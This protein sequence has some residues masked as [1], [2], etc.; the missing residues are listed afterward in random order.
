MRLKTARANS[1][2]YLS[3]LLLRES[4]ADVF[5]AADVVAESSDPLRP[6]VAPTTTT[7]APLLQGELNT[8]V[9]SETWKLGLLLWGNRVAAVQR[10]PS[11]H[12]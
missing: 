12:M 7:T 6:S 3:R 10:Y 11:L 2:L 5:A 4:A 9:S 1:V 8:L